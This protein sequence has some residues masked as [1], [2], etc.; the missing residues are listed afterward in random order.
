MYRRPDITRALIHL[1]GDRTSSEGCSAEQAL[2]SILDEGKIRGS[3]STGF[4]KGMNT[5]TCFTEMPLSSLKYF[6]K[7]SLAKHKY[8]YYGIA[9][10]KTK[11]WAI[12]ARPVIYL[13][14]EE[15]EWIPPE[16]KWR[17]VR[18]EHDNHIDFT[19]EREWRCK[20]DF[21]LTGSGIYVIVPD[22]DTE[23]RLRHSQKH[24]SVNVTG[25]LH[26]NYLND[27]L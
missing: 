5:A 18:F 21:D 27:L 14:D 17:H 19:H 15:A 24:D 23:V 9:I 20:G 22:K 11:G 7:T 12:G 26:M 16:E 4:I 2:Q 3:G 13:P 1:T 8:K 10:P 6:I 25:F